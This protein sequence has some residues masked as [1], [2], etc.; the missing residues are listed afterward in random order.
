[1]TQRAIV[2]LP[3]PDSP[4][5]PSVS[6]F[7]T[8]KVTPSTA[9]TRGDF[10]LEDDPARDGEVLLEVLDDEQLVARGLPAR[11]LRLRLGA[12]SRRVSEVSQLR[13]LAVLR[14]LVEVAA[15]EVRRIVRDGRAARAP[16]PCR[17]PSR[18]GSAGGSGSRAAG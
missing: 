1:M 18:T 4:T 2:D 6:P 3:Q 12:S 17:P 7:L 14:L 11:G 8:V 5:T 10:L 16:R 13:R 15:L 9:F